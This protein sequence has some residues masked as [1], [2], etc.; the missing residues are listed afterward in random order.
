VRACSSCLLRLGLGHLAERYALRTSFLK[1]SPSSGSIPWEAFSIA[2]TNS[3]F[4][5]TLGVIAKFKPL[6]RTFLCCVLS[7]VLDRLTTHLS[8][9]SSDT[10]PSTDS[11]CLFFESR[12]RS[13]FCRWRAFVLTNSFSWTVSTWVNTVSASSAGSTHFTQLVCLQYSARNAV[14]WLLIKRILS[15]PVVIQRF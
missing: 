7:S 4:G 2:I 9:C 12:K 8:H 5:R 11:S 15:L 13:N 1:T 3:S 14:N 10:L 6:A